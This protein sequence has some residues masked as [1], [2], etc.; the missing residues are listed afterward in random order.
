[1]AWFRC[2]LNGVSP[3]CMIGTSLQ[4]RAARR[5]CLR[6]FRQRETL[7]S[8]RLRDFLR[9]H[10]RQ[11]EQLRGAGRFGASGANPKSIQSAPAYNQIGGAGL[12]FP[13]SLLAIPTHAVWPYVQQYN[14][15]VQGELPSHTVLQVAY[16]G[17]LGRHLPV[18]TEYNQLQ[19]LS[20]GLNPY[21][22]GQAISGDDCGSVSGTAATGYTGTVNGNAGKRNRRHP[23]RHRLRHLRRPV[24]PVLRHQRNHA[25]LEHRPV[26]IQRSP[27]R[28]QPILRPPERKPGLYLRPFD[29][30]WL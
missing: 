25:Q 15:A 21:A 9:A 29:R 13:L 7:G 6:C 30:R 20:P 11:R 22:P 8:R 24:P 14:L 17:S 18:R 12:Q 1:M 23:P 10:Q 16:V 5:L 2:G 27:G 4:S 28:S 3:G 26:G 19:P